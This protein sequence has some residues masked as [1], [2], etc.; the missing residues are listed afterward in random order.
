MA[1]THSIALAAASSQSLSITDGSQ[2]GLDLSGDFTIEAWIKLTQLPSTAGT[3]FG[4]VSK[5]HTTGSSNKA[6]NQ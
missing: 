6:A 1:N 2:T 3:E 5:Y 4:I